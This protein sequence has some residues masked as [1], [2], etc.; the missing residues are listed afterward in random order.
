MKVPLFINGS[1]NAC[2]RSLMMC[3]SLA[4]A[5][6]LIGAL[7]V[8]AD[9]PAMGASVDAGCLSPTAIQDALINGRVLRLADIRH[10]LQGD[11]VSADLCRNNGK[12]AYLVTVL[13]PEGIVR[14]V[15]VDANS[16]EM[17]YVRPH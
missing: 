15:S 3:R 10:K 4:T 17:V 5:I 9:A 8:P 12:L 1:G 2:D 11:I 14:R 7:C 16:G 6:L 13:T